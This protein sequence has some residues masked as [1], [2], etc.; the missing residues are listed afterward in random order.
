MS[1]NTTS[2]T[3]D[4]SAEFDASLDLPAGMFR[5]GDNP[6]TTDIR[7]P[8]RG[9]NGKLDLL[10]EEVAYTVLDGRAIFEGDIVLGNAEDVRGDDVLSKGIG[11]LGNQFRWPG[12]RVPYV[13][14]EVLKP[15]VQ[16][17]INHWEEKTPI[18]F[19][20]RNTHKHY[21]SFEFA[22][23]CSSSVGRQ[24]GKQ[25][26]RLGTACGVGSAIHEIG[27]ALGLWH[28]QSR[29]D[30]D[31]FIEIITNNINPLRLRNFDKHI[32]DG[33]DLGAYD[34][35]SIMHYPATAFTINGQPTIRVLG[36]Q[37][38]GQ[39]NGL[40]AGDIAAIKLLYPNLNW[41]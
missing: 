16:K 14:E 28:E 1:D 9:E 25:L 32:Q 34:F 5:S 12:G 38:I 17:A 6:E 23:E 20:P 7:M 22:N 3:N 15:L 29:S 37:S 31:N 2:S 27:H 36:G 18:R 41:P 35:G 30:R 13:V 11:R 19:V 4:A 33:I 26:I 10:F 21:I 39:R 40:S 8:K 24:G